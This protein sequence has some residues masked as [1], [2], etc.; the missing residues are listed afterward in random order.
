MKQRIGI[1]LK[2][3]STWNDLMTKFK[4]FEAT[5]DIGQRETAYGESSSTFANVPT[6]KNTMNDM[7]TIWRR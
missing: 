5:E 1:S 3:F 2:I 4:H 6:G 7:R